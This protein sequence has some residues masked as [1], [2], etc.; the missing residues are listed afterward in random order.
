MSDSEIFSN[1]NKKFS[2]NS[3]DE[4]SLDF[5]YLSESSDSEVKIIDTSKND[6]EIDKNENITT[7]ID[8][9]NNDQSNN[10]FGSYWI[11][12]NQP[13][14]INEPVNENI[15]KSMDLNDSKMRKNKKKRYKEHNRRKAKKQEKRNKKFLYK[16]ALSNE[17][18]SNAIKNNDH[19]KIKQCLED[20]MKELKELKN[21]IEENDYNIHPYSDEQINEMKEKIKL[22]L[23]INKEIRLK[24]LKDPVMVENHKQ[25]RMRYE[26]SKKRKRDKNE[27]Q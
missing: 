27:T 7:N 13:K 26:M 22:G 1:M 16:Y 8:D 14:E 3:K 18:L 23:K 11:N 5:I 12:M 15:H 19:L 17:K 10:K 20:S 6:N 25:R 2:I 24:I 4:H 9:V 21:N